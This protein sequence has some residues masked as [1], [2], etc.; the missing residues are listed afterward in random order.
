MAAEL[1]K[2]P[3]PDALPTEAVSPPPSL[4]LYGLLTLTALA[5][6]L[7]GFWD[8]REWSSLF[9]NLATELLGAVI[10]LLVVERRLRPSEMRT[11]RLV[12]ARAKVLSVLVISPRRRQLYKSTRAL[13]ARLEELTRDS[14]RLKEIDDLV[15]KVSPGF[16]LTGDPGSGKTTWLQLIARDLASAYLR[17]PSGSKAPILFTARLWLPDRTLE[18]ALCEHVCAF[19]PISLHAFRAAMRKGEVIVMLDGV[20]EVWGRVPSFPDELERRRTCYPHPGWVLSIRSQY[21]TPVR[22]LQVIS[23]RDLT[24][25]EVYTILR[26]RQAGRRSV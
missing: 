17:D 24:E 14:V 13:L 21:P 26:R 6:I 12:P 19:A 4:W 15:L 23:M 10:I 25:E 3:Q 1:P 7:V 9:L 18:E 11:L 2:E 8:R 16:V 22:D 20:D 5:L